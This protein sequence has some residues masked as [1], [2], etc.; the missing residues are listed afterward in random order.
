MYGHNSSRVYVNQ[1][2]EEAV[3]GGTAGNKEVSCG[4]SSRFNGIFEI[5][6]PDMQSLRVVRPTAADGRTRREEIVK[7]GQG[8]RMMKKKRSAK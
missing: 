2:T 1:K 4:V 3:T 6:Q 8:I 5:S 7:N